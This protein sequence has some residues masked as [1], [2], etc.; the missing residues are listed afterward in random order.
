MAHYVFNFS[1]DDRGAAASLL[2][3]KLWRI[4]R[5]EQHSQ[6]LAARDL[7]LVY[8]ASD[9]AFI[10]RVE[11]ATPVHDWTMPEA[12]AYPGDSRG[13]VLLSHVEEWHPPVSMESVVRRIDPTGS[14]PL[15][16]ENAAAG[17]R[18]GVIRITEDEYKAAL[19]LRVR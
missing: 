5:E 1:S 14:N 11:V 6:E 16:Q 13:G 3:A 15:V 8:V 12:A 18:M 17:F 9:R 4:G 10:G 7:A 19:G 2:R